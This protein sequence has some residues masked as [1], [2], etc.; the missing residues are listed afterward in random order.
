MQIV[1]NGSSAF[2]YHWFQDRSQQALPQ[3]FIVSLPM[4]AY[5]VAMLAWS[6]WLAFAIVRWVRWGW[7][8]YSSGGIWNRTRPADDL[9]VT[10]S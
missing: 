7:A 4:W 9:A 5:R 2:D 8:T 10:P 1:G 3:A 6:L